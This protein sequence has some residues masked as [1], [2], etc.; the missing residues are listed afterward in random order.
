M[1]KINESCFIESFE[2]KITKNNNTYFTIG[3]IPRIIL[4]I[5]VPFIR[6][7]NSSLKQSL[8]IK[9]IVFYD[10]MNLFLITQI[11]EHELIIK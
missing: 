5:V 1:K 4:N 2:F 11:R 8:S 9:Y 6:L 3:L 7:C 10:K